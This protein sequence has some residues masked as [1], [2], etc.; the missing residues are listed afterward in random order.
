[1]GTLVNIYNH[2]GMMKHQIGLQHEKYC[3]PFYLHGVKYESSVAFPSIYRS[4]N[5]HSQS[6]FIDLQTPLNLHQYPQYKQTTG[7]ALPY[8]EKPIEHVN[9]YSD[10][11]MGIRKKI[12]KKLKKKQKKYEIKI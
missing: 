4:T 11:E 12:K 6:S 8:P 2:Q 7:Q 5:L 9:I 3:D 10:L 1:M